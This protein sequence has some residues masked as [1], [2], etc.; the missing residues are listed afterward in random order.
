MLILDSSG[1]INEVRFGIIK[2]MMVDTVQQL[3]VRP[4]RTRV[5]LV[6]WSDSARTAFTL[7]D[8]SQVKQ[9]VITAIL[10]VPFLG[11]KTHT[12]DALRL[13]CQVRKHHNTVQ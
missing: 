7:L 9:D 4:D 13:S 5:G 12:S 1:S 11:N 10:R 3:D 8:Y 2:Q 6:Y